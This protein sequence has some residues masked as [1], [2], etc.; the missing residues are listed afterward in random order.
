MAWGGIE[1]SA[2]RPRNQ[3]FHEVP[4]KLLQKL[5]QQTRGLLPPITPTRHKGQSQLKFSSAPLKACGAVTLQACAVRVTEGRD[6]KT[7]KEL[8]SCRADS[9]RPCLAPYIQPARS[10][11]TQ[12]QFFYT[13]FLPG[14]GESPGPD[15]CVGATA[16]WRWIRQT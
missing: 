6:A 9:S 1:G 15:R 3:G 12:H 4:K 5:L 10:L 14:G 11:Q 2:Q 13:K 8:Q 7:I 16:M